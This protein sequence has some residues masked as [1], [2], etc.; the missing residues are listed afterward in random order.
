MIIKGGSRAAPSQLAWHLQRLDTNEKVEIL[1]V[2]SPTPDL[3]EAF[4]NWQTLSEGTHGIKGL[5][6]A[7][8][9]PAKDYIMT[10]DQWQRAVDVL[11]KELHLEG[12]PRAVVMHEKLGREHIH[13]VWARTDID[14]MV[15]CPDSQNY[16]AHERASQRLEMEFGHEQVPGKHAKR[17]REKQ[18]EF[19]RA[20]ANQAEWQQG[21]RTGIDPASRKD[22]ITALKQASDNA[23]AFKVALEE[24]GY[25]LA[26]GDRRDFVIVDQTGSIHS[27][28]RQ[29]RDVKAAELREFMKTIDREALPTTAEAKDL[30]RQRQQ[31]A[32]QQQEPAQQQPPQQEP[33]EQPKQQESQEQES[34]QQE[35]TEQQ[36]TAPQESQPQETQQQPEAE[37]AS[38]P[39][40][41]ASDPLQAQTEALR[42]AL[43]ERQAEEGRKL[44]ESQR[45]EMDQL[46]A[47]LDR[48]IRENLDRR[49][50]NDRREA[51]DLRRR[52]KQAR[53][54]FDGV[55]DSVWSFFSP[56]R[57]AER[58]AERQREQQRFAARQKQE[59]DDYAAFLQQTN[60][61]EIENREEL[62]AL[63]LHDLE[64]RGA[65]ERDRYL[66]EQELARE[67][68]AENEER[69]RQ[70]AEQ[71]ARDGPKKRAR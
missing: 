23:Q 46:R 61:L 14:R 67:L 29:I 54:S 19:P 27:L 35:T 2:Q 58:E 25:I 41:P 38:T 52:Q 62:H 53:A 6:H 68:Q 20:E 66:R 22:Q 26:K 45:A 3:A 56:A 40:E 13:V 12:Q 8:I 57:A 11:E 24:Q 64:V 71:R 33:Q 60:K 63:R 49:D 21:E 32:P 4:R 47:D 15:L 55:I 34:S 18:R 37:T 36:E 59:R 50:A 10:R 5:Y 28:G 69:E 1:E 70:L 16:L 48:N 43:A 51:E 31:E 7:N 39:P 44:V 9:D 17:D 65:E 30:Q 42:K